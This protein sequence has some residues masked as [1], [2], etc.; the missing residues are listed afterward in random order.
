MTPLQEAQT[1]FSNI[2]NSIDVH[3]S[4]N[5]LLAKQAQ[6]QAL[7]DS[8]PNTPELNPIAD[9]IADVQPKL[10]GMVTQA[11]LISLQSREQTLKEATS[12]ITHVA[13]EANA[14]A[15]S[16]SF[17]KPKLVLATLTQSI[18][19]LRDIKATA[20]AQN[21]EAAAVKIDAVVT[22]IEQARNSIKTT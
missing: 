1:R 6:L 5:D 14:N 3:M 11:V 18:D 17:E 16:L 7:Q 21:F 20:Q 2:I 19:A 4:S 10:M 8:L 15:R 13:T 9:A 12:L 22:L